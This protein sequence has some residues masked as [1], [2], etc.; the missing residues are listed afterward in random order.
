MDSSWAISTM[1][2]AIASRG[3]WKRTASPS[4]STLTG[5]YLPLLLTAA[6]AVSADWAAYQ[7]AP[8]ITV[9]SAASA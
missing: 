4:S 8:Q 2:R 3:E 1:P 6:G 9:P 7:S 5:E